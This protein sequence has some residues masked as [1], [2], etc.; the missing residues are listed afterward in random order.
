MMPKL[1][2]RENGW[3][4]P[5]LCVNKALSEAEHTPASGATRKWTLAASRI[6]GSADPSKHLVQLEQQETVMRIDD[7]EKIARALNLWALFV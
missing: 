3:A 6:D 7:L 2:R 4:I 5:R 1:P